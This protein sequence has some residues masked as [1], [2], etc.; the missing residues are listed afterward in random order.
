MNLLISAEKQIIY[1]RRRSVDWAPS[2]ARADQK[3]VA[4]VDQSTPALLPG[5]P[6]HYMGRAIETCHHARVFMNLAAQDNPHDAVREALEAAAR[7]L[8]TR[9]GNIIYVQ[10]WKRAA[11]LIRARIS[12]YE[13][14]ADP[15]QASHLA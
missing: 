15:T 4:S 8:E 2:Q 5:Q 12:Q 3:Q 6:R 13:Q 14:T 7:E 9:A 1:L 10:A 11:K